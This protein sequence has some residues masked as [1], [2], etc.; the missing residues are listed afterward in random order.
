MWNVIRDIA[1]NSGVVLS[2]N[3]SCS[4]FLSFFISF[5]L[6]F[7]LSFNFPR[8]TVFLLSPFLSELALLLFLP[9]SLAL[10]SLACASLYE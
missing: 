8:F 4:L 2:G 5:F 10:C 3:A 9:L 6:S 7:F 1:N